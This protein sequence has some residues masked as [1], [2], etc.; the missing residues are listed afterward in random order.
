MILPQFLLLNVLCFLLPRATRHAVWF[1]STGLVRVIKRSQEHVRHLKFVL[2]RFVLDRQ[3]SQ[4]RENINFPEDEV[5]GGSEEGGEG[6]AGLISP[7][8][9]RQSA[10]ASVS[11][12]F[13]PW[14][15]TTLLV[16]PQVQPS[17]YP[18]HRHPSPSHL[19][20]PPAP[21]AKRSRRL[22]MKTSPSASPSPSRLQDLSQQQRKEAWV[23]VL[24][25]FRYV[26]L[27]YKYIQ[28]MHMNNVLSLHNTLICRSDLI[29][30]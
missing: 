24:F 20:V 2:C 25:G 28:Y 21:A 10:S 15:W 30:I 11:P 29:E 19:R 4:S 14:C 7:G 18:E 17:P 3:H 13:C 9:S 6:P 8:K 26:F 12:G 23:D 5:V 16:S 1:V 27:K 22:K